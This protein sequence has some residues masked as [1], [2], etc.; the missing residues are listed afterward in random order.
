MAGLLL[1]SACDGNNAVTENNLADPAGKDGVA[2]VLTSVSIRESTKGAKPSGFVKLGKSVRV[3]LVATEALMA[4]VVTIND[5]EA[6]VTGKVNSWFAVREMAEDDPLGEVTFTV[7]Y[8][9]ISGE[10]GLF[11]NSTTDGST[12]IY[13]DDETVA[14]PEPVSLPGDWKLDPQVDNDLV[15]GAGVG[16]ASGDISWWNTGQTA[17]GIIPEIRDCWFDDVFRFSSDGSFRN[18]Q[19]DETWLEPWQGVEAE[20]CGAPVAPHDGSSAGTWEYDEAAST[21][22]I[23]GAGSH[24]GLAKA[25]NG[26]E[27]PNVAVPDSVVYDVV[28][29]EGDSMT[30]TIDVGGGTWWTFTLIRQPASPLAG[31]W[32]LDPQVGNEEVAGAGVGPNSGDIS[33]WNT[34]QEAGA[35]VAA[36]A[37]W[38][39]DVFVFGE[40]GSFQNIQ[41]DDTWL[42]A[43][44][45]AD[46][47][48][49][50][51]PVAPHDGSNGAIFQYDEDAATLMLTGKGAHLG[52]A[53]AVNGA[54]LGSPSETPESVTYTVLILD[55][56][57]MTVTV[58]VGTGWWTFTL[59]RVS[60]SPFVGKWKL[61]PQV[62]NDQVAGAGVG[63]GSGDISW[64]NT[65]Q[66][67]GAIVEARACWFDDVFH[68]GDD[69]SFQ[70]YHGD[71]TWL[72]AWQGADPDS[73]GAP[74]MPHDGSTAGTWRYDDAAGTMELIGAG[75]YLGLAKVVNGGELPNV[76]VPESV[77]YQVLS[78]E[79]DSMTVTVDVGEGSWWTFSL[80]RAND[81]AALAGQW[82]L[83]PEI[84]NAEVAGAGVGPNS[85]DISWW[86]TGQEDGAIVAARACWFDDVFTFG[87]DGSF[88]ND[89]GDDTWLEAWQGADPDSCGTP[90]F[91]HD[92]SARAIFE[93]DE[94][95]AQL[96]VHGKGAH[97]GL[98]KA[99]NGGE[100]TDPGLAPDSVTYDVLVLDGD[101]MTV[102]VNVETG[103][104][105]FTL[106]RV[107]NL[108]I[109]GNW[110]LDPVVGNDALAGAGVGPASGDISWW[111]TGQEDGA[112]VEARAC[113]F[114]DVFHF[115]GGG[116]FQNFQDGETWLEAWQGADPDSC[117][118]PVAPHDGGTTGSFT[119][120]D[121]ASSLSV[122]GAGSHIG[123]AK[124][125]NGAELPNVEVPESIDYSVLSF[126]AGTMTVTIDVGG[127]SWWTFSLVKE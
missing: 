16:P 46:P 1:L 117:G 2:P 64:W 49:C 125:V 47:D 33:W 15:A 112:I 27:L 89:Q 85:G 19:G 92:G 77:V 59:V 102:T 26:G 5:V 12:L 73:C 113:W 88:M 99:V 105:T 126:D 11:A 67:D 20:S 103:W 17:G 118:T 96:T 25:V 14:C 13:C 116:A 65:G 6:K 111:N 60:N 8:Q 122:R 124:V 10:A 56:D 31:K 38:F 119:Y 95:A 30:V 52:L 107:S 110:K 66:E 57:T 86:N 80:V 68:F 104:W 9:D 58:D 7:T 71:E 61:D 23:T 22:R 24:L 4:P 62:G 114:D 21:I 53:K 72:E 35:I 120:D 98:A 91:P 32:Q 48:S 115:G 18:V 87:A 41:G 29:L 28:A 97:I 69:G 76:A 108:P 94:V 70:N 100:L 90:V 123:L 106:V 40:D 84:G 3:D 74:V 101:T 45:G 44:Q 42:E 39:D 127:G 121:A 55:G 79:G 83:D 50:G 109:V 37:C 51:A 43:W 93:Y 75:S 82:R 63:P 81:S 36:R 78:Q 34:G 54:E